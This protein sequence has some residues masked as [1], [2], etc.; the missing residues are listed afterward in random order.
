[1][2]LMSMMNN[3]TDK[4]GKSKDFF[5]YSNPNTYI[6]LTTTTAFESINMHTHTSGWL[7]A[8]T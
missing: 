3:M 5:F 7:F 2:L 8:M 1:M 6:T 4:I